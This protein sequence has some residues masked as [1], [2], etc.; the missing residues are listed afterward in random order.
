MLLMI[1]EDGNGD[2]LQDPQAI[3]SS[4]TVDAIGG[5]CRQE[6]GVDIIQQTWSKLSDGCTHTLK[7][8]ESRS[9]REPK[10]EQSILG[11]M[12]FVFPHL[13]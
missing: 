4:Q 3:D 2:G 7:F 13:K 12:M 9:M 1:T 6:G 8:D 5:E 11:T 10:R